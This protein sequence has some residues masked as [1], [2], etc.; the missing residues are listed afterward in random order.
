MKKTLAPIIISL[1]IFA[2]AVITSNHLVASASGGILDTSLSSDYT[3][4]SL[5]INTGE[6]FK[7]NG[8]NVDI[9]TGGITINSGGI[10]DATSGAGGNSLITVEGNWTNNGTFTAGSSTVTFDG[11]AA[12]IISGY[13]TFYYLT[14]SNTHPID[15]VDINNNI[16]VTMNIDITDGQV[17]PQPGAVFKTNGYVY[18]RSGAELEMNTGAT[19]QLKAFIIN[20][21]LDMNDGTISWSIAGGYVTQLNTMGLVDMTGGLWELNNDLAMYGILNQSGGTISISRNT[22]GNWN[23]YSGSVASL[24]GGT[25]NA[26]GLIL[27]DGCEIYAH[28]THLL[29]IDKANAIIRIN[30][31]S[32]HFQNVTCA[33][34]SS[35]GS[36]SKYT[37]DVNGT[38]IINNGVTFTTNGIN[39]EV[40][41]DWTNNGIF[42]A[43]SSTVTFDGSD[44]QFMTGDTTFYQL[45]ISNT[46]ASNP[47]YT[48]TS[49]TD[50]NCTYLDITDGIFRIDSGTTL[51][52]THTGGS[53][54]E[55]S[56]DAELK[57]NS[58]II[59]TNGQIEL[60]GSLRM[61]NGTFNS[62][63]S[64]ADLLILS[65]GG[66]LQVDNGNCNI[67]PPDLTG[68]G[69]VWLKETNTEVEL[70]DGT[71]TI[72]DYFWAYA[73][74]SNLDLNGGTMIVANRGN[75]Q[76]YFPAFVFDSGST[77]NMDGSTTSLK[78][79]GQYPDSSNRMLDWDTGANIN[80]NDGTI[81]LELSSFGPNV[82][83][84]IDFGGHATKNLVVD[85]FGYTTYLL[86]NNVDV[87]GD[88]SILAGTFDAND[89]D[90]YVAGHWTN[91]GTFNPGLGTVTFDGS[92]NSNIFGSPTFYYLRN[93]KSNAITYLRDNVSC[94]KFYNDAGNFDGNGY[95]LTMT[96]S[97]SISWYGTIYM[98]SG[99]LTGNS[100]N[101]RLYGTL[102]FSTGSSTLNW[103]EI[104]NGGVFWG[105]TGTHNLIY[106]G[107]AGL[108]NYSGGIFNTESS[109][110]NITTGSGSGV[111][112][113]GLIKINNG[114]IINVGTYVYIYEGGEIQIFNNS[115]ILDVGTDIYIYSGTPNGIL[116]CDDGVTAYSPTIYVGGNWTNNGIFN[117]GSSTVTFDGALNQNV[118][119]SNFYNL[120][121]NKTGGSLVQDGDW[122]VNG[123]FMGTAGGIQCLLTYN[124]Y[125]AGNLTLNHGPGSWNYSC[126]WRLDGTNQSI[127]G[128]NAFAP[129][130]VI[131]S[132]ST[133][134]INNNFTTYGGIT[135]SPEAKLIL[136]DNVT[137]KIDPSSQLTIA[138]ELETNSGSSNK[139]AITSRNPPSYFDFNVTGLLDINGLAISYIS[140]NGLNIQPGADIYQLNNVDFSNKESRYITFGT[141]GVSQ[142]VYNNCYFS[143]ASLYNV[144]MNAAEHIY[145]YNSSGAGGGP[146]G[147][148]YDYDGGGGIVTWA[149]LGEKHWAGLVSSLWN[150]SNNWIPVGVPTSVENIFITDA[151]FDPILD[152]TGNCKDITIE[153]SGTLSSNSYTLNVYGDWTNNGTFNPG[154]GTVI[155]NG[156]SNQAISNSET[157]YG[158]N[159]NK[160]GGD[161]KIQDGT[162]I[163]INGAFAV[164]S[165]PTITGTSNSG[166]MLT[167]NGNIN[168]PGANF[169]YANPVTIAGNGTVTFNNV[170]FENF[171]NS[172]GSK[173]LYITRASL[174][175][176]FDA[177]SFGPGPNG[178]DRFNVHMNATN[179]AVFFTNF[180]SS[181]G[182][183]ENYD[184]DEAGNTYWADLSAKYWLG[185]ESTSWND[186]N[187]WFP[188]GVPLSSPRVDL[189]IPNGNPFDP[190]LDT[191]GYCA[192]ITIFQGGTLTGSDGLNRTLYISGDWTNSGTFNPGTG[193]V[194]FDGSENSTISRDMTDFLVID[195]GDV[196][197]GEFS[198]YS[199]DSISSGDFATYSAD[200]M[201]NYAVIFVTAFWPGNQTD[202]DNIRAAQSN[203]EAYVNGG[204]VYV[205]NMA[206]NS[207]DQNDLAPGG[208]D[209]DKDPLHD[210]EIF[211]MP[212]HP[213]LT[214]LHYGGNTLTTADFDNWNSTDHGQVMNYPIGSEIVLTN[215]DGKSW[216]HYQWGDGH[217]IATS[218]TYLSW[219]NPKA[220]RNEITYSKY[221]SNIAELQFYNLQVDKIDSAAVTAN[222]NVF[223]DSELTINSGTFETSGPVS[224]VEITG[225]LTISSN[226][227]FQLTSGGLNLYTGEGGATD[228]DIDGTL[229]L[230]LASD[231]GNIYWYVLAGSLVDIDAGGTA[232]FDG[233]DNTNMVYLRSS[234]DGTSWYLNDHTAAT[235]NPTVSHTNVKDSNAGTPSPPDWYTIYAFDG[236]NVDS[237]GNVNWLFVLPD[238]DGD[239]IFDSVDNCP[240][241]YNPYQEDADEDGV[242]DA[243][244]NCP[245][246]SNSDQTDTDN[247]GTGN[248]CDGCPED[249]DKVE[250]GDCGCGVPDIDSDS[251]GIP[252]CNDNCPD[253][254]NPDQVDIDGDGIGYACDNVISLTS[255]YAADSLII[256][257]GITFITNGYNIDIGTGGITIHS[258]GV[259]D[260]NSGVGGDSFITD[261]GNWSNSGTFTAG[262]STVTFDGSGTIGGTTPDT[263]YNLSVA[264]SDQTTTLTKN[265]VVS[266]DLTIDRGMYAGAYTTTVEGYTKALDSSG[267]GNNGMLRNGPSY[268]SG[269]FSEGI[270]FDGSNDYVNCDNNESLDLPAAFTIEAW[271]KLDSIG[272]WQTIISKAGANVWGEISY[273]LSITPSGIIQ[274]AVDDGTNNEYVNGGTTLTTGTWYHVAAVASGSQYQIYLN[275]NLDGTGIQYCSPQVIPANLNIGMHS[276]QQVQHFHG[277]IDE[278][279]I[280]DIARYTAAFIPSSVP[281]VSDA[282]TVG[283]WHL[284][285]PQTAAYDSS[286][287]GNEGRLMN[288]ATY[289]Q[290]HFMG[291]AESTEANDYIE[292]PSIDIGAAWTIEA[293]F[294]YPLATMATWNTLTRGSSFDHQI[295]VQRGVMQLGTY[296]NSGGTGFRGCGYNM[297]LLSPGWHHIAAV[298]AGTTTSFYIDG[299]LIGISS[300]KSSS[301]IR[302]IGNHFIGGQAWGT[303]DEVRISDIARYSANFAPPSG[304]FT[305]DENTVGLWH[306]DYPVLIAPGSTVSGGTLEIAPF[307]DFY[308]FGSH[309]SSNLNNL[310]INAS[311]NTI[312]MANNI[313]CDG[314][315]DVTTGILNTGSNYDLDINGNV[316]ISGVLSVGSSA[317]SIYCAGDW[318]NNGTFIPGTGTVTF[319]G[320]GDL[321]SGGTPAGAFNNLVVSSGTRNVITDSVKI[322]GL[323][324]LNSGSTFQITSGGLDLYTGE[325]GTTDVD[326]DGTLKLELTS[327]SGNI[328]WYVLA[329]SLVDIDAG[330][331]VIFDGFNNSN[332]ICLRSS[333]DGTSWHL[334]DHTAATTN[335]TV[336]YTDVKDCNAGTPSPPD[337]YTIYGFDG[338]NVDSS[339]NVNWLFVLPDADGDGIFDSVDNCPM[340]YNPDQED[341]DEDGVGD[342]CDN[343]PATSNPDQTDTDSD[344]TGD[345][346]DGCPNDPDKVEPGE[347]GCGVP[348]IDSDSDGIPDCN[349][350]CPDVANPDQTDADEDGIGDACDN[351]PDVTNPDQ[352][353]F[354]GD[355]IGDACDLCPEDL[356]NDIDNDGICGDVDNCPTVSNP[357]QIDLD[358]DGVG[359]ACDNC[360]EVPNPDQIDSDG[361]TKQE[362]ISY[363]KFDE[364]IGTLALDS[365]D[366]NDGTVYGATWIT[367][368]VGD[369]LSFDGVDDYVLIPQDSSLEP[370]SNI[371]LECWINANEQVNGVIVGKLLNDNI[372]YS[373]V[374]AIQNGMLTFSV[375]S[376]EADCSPSVELNYAPY[377]NAWHHIA[378]TYDGTSI[379]LYVD[380]LPAN[381][382]YY[383][384]N[385]GYY[386]SQ[387]YV[388]IIQVPEFGPNYF[389][390]AFI[391]KIDEVAIY[392]RALP[393]SEISQHY[394][395][396]LDGL[397][398]LSDGL[399]DACDQCPIE[400]ATGFDV[401][402][403][404]CVD[405]IEDFV[406]IIENLNL[407]KGIENSLTSKINNAQKLLDKGN[408]NAAINL[409]EAFINHVKAQSGKK[410]PEEDANMLIEY[411]NNIIRQIEEGN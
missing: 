341:A 198:G 373:Y 257:S 221:L 272:T 114:G 290:G 393:S 110:V 368:I 357:D 293:W 171:I 274:L 164:A 380:G 17:R 87:N 323:L 63:Y 259:L 41:G 222:K 218:L 369:T 89:Q 69:G 93:A 57:C 349:D 308:G 307:A 304:P 48:A 286:T 191:D 194:S 70:N 291:G 269:I 186:P 182:E 343:C 166:Y 77:L 102:D 62:T 283:L 146:S 225:K 346:C 156:S 238:A 305:P 295:I 280:S 172:S 200:Q 23:C 246:T 30:D 392:D 268:A 285:Y 366:A 359:D 247:D 356:E 383:D 322:N 104:Y 4:N 350:N 128:T 215:V 302:S 242:G 42:N 204:G 328:Y 108:I 300:F 44:S 249:P 351:C 376:A 382:D 20:G 281:F 292:I 278:L 394:L 58:G 237:S 284:D 213:Y 95:D 13:T 296:D 279:R 174:I 153:S 306:F 98:R 138:G 154:F 266:D 277:H 170:T 173:Y 127:S 90:M 333:S 331:T 143:E 310:R 33:A 241:V 197:W 288:G 47:V 407:P 264:A 384:K 115:S 282:N 67:G 299:N 111:M 180:G 85:R 388:G 55:I 206:G 255:D 319:D 54:V 6:T 410:I 202:Y 381:F 406:D 227:E 27:N 145:F 37:L 311:T 35:I 239:G 314:N 31:D 116:D 408:D 28:G 324:V 162:T 113:Y 97:G 163:I 289:T 355:G 203:V 64:S 94:N 38:F 263:F 129:N 378:G 234:S 109:T 391:G 107:G 121:I 258:G 254:S 189:F 132:G 273:A 16:T 220:F 339:G 271:I 345:A 168:I 240:V 395:K 372:Y 71:L 397:G 244:D 196:N 120:T 374:L 76:P 251:D 248:A 106:S 169:R 122:D 217:V 303:I 49:G 101:P 103:L 361:T 209:F 190:T 141:T 123:D 235:T 7:T 276:D 175:Q 125:F 140:T 337:W 66:K 155:F 142:I 365:V 219:A 130:V 9:S 321:K 261:E 385:I 36:A 348:D 212:S 183:G 124:V 117:S 375:C 149:S 118:S 229:K 211:A 316:V 135:V 176:S 74:G 133:T 43:G 148:D 318:T 79:R 152:A 228:V 313:S 336:S 233:F 136:S 73:S 8:Y 409:L 81:Y 402:G 159:I 92:S 260:G 214:G 119:A 99:T 390:D 210:A 230:E 358:E 53:A 60:N 75:I 78:I 179:T 320:S 3:A 32:S 297:S 178:V 11:S 231:T 193:R 265:I 188:L 387:V 207:G 252:D 287:H 134:A 195:N 150:D 370:E 26:S 317:S 243:C 371:T 389:L 59:T 338:T 404:G 46:H 61:V 312:T 364:G 270:R 185:S 326:I 226:A 88:F 315:L 19:T 400:D 245:A 411:A 52:V 298:G 40:S 208:V 360:P 144:Y 201:K 157:F 51:D 139:P 22:L 256:N 18:I 24:T 80:I 181:G 267:N 177:C 147:E 352:A 5:T 165:T 50:I 83:G 112:V 398:Y 377:Y 399:G 15:Y 275:G 205:I 86:D 161:L 14:I 160:S 363:W 334:N 405:R 262:S 199:Y 335:P 184:W 21:L 65:S 347:C 2:I 39:M 100:V 330:G 84:Y 342:A 232:I 72:N 68:R 386:D 216:I 309:I 236:T 327:A 396:G 29:N 45:T 250:P 354:D 253:I 82:T 131:T 192:D 301:D 12:Q 401:N 367:G 223:V 10:L 403:D 353:D 294:Q 332:M 137:L 187:N 340:V 91:N 158:L 34:N 329:D 25:I 224:K 167:L 1:F 105:G 96:G 126:S 379:T 362:F 56:N 344:G 325:G 151:P